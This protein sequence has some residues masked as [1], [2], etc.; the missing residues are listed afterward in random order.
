MDSPK[1]LYVQYNPFK[2]N[3]A[4]SLEESGQED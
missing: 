2:Y 1:D 4:V 3:N